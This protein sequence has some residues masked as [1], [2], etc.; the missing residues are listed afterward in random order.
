MQ[1]KNKI[2][3][4]RKITIRQ[5]T[6]GEHISKKVAILSSEEADGMRYKNNIESNNWESD[7]IYLTWHPIFVGTFGAA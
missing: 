6:I 4:V 5:L 3:E 1:L 7:S 2:T